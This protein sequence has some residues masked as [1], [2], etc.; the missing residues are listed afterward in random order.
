M[1]IKSALLAMLLSQPVDPKLLDMTYGPC[2][3]LYNKYVEVYKQ[4]VVRGAIM[5]DNVRF[6]CTPIKYIKEDIE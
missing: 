1:L 5:G 3:D 6:L 2:V 4:D